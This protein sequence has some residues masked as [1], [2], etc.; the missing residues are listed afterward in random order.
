MDLSKVESD[1][2]ANEGAIMH[3]RDP[4]DDFPAYFTDGEGKEHPVTMTVLGSDS[5]FYHQ[6]MLDA[7]RKFTRKKNNDP[8]DLE[9]AALKTMAR[10][11]VRWD[12]F[13][14]GDKPI[15]CNF[16]NALSLLEKHRW[17]RDQ[18]REFQEDRANFFKS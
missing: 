3:V 8:K 9:D 15:V 13:F 18:V 10:C 17:L 11:I 12:G 14:D 2:I 6:A 4:A 5:D 1:S 7:S 16:E